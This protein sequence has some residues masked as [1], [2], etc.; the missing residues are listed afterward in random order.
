MVG[1]ERTSKGVRMHFPGAWMMALVLLCACAMYLYFTLGRIDDGDRVAYRKLSQSLDGTEVASAYT[2]KQQRRGL[3][4]DLLYNDKGQRLQMRLRSAVAEL[5]LDHHDGKVDIVENMSGVTCYIQEELFYQLS[6]GREAVRQADGR[7]LIKHAKPEDQIS[8]VSMDAP[9][10]EAM[11]VVRFFESDRASYYY[12][13]GRLVA[14]NVKVLRYLA[15]GH[16]IEEALQQ[17]VLIMSGVASFAEFNLKEANND[18]EKVTLRGNVVIEHEQGRYSAGHV[19]LFSKEGKGKDS[20]GLLRMNDDVKL[21][22]KDGGELCCGLAELDYRDQVGK[23]AGNE[24]QEFVVYKEQPA[25]KTQGSGVCTPLMVKSR[26]MAVTLAAVKRAVETSQKNSINSI[27]AEDQVTV[28]YNEDIVVSADYADYRRAEPEVVS[29]GTLLSGLITMYTATEGGL[30]QVSDSSGDLIEATRINIDTTKKQLV[31]IQPKGTLE[32]IAGATNLGRIDFIADRLEWDEQSGVFVLQDHVGVDQNGIGKLET[33]KEMRCYLN[34]GTRNKMLKS[35]ETVSDTTL[36]YH[37]AEK[38][39]HHNLFCSG[40]V[41]VDHEKME[42]RLFALRDESGKVSEDKQIHFKDPRGEVFADRVLI[43]YAT[44]GSNLEITRIILAGNVKVVN[45]P[46]PDDEE[47]PLLQY[48]LADRV[49]FTPQ[50]NEMVFRAIVKG[51]RVLFYD[52]TN[53]LQVSAPAIKINRDM[54]TKK[55]AIKGIGDVRFSFIESEFAQLRR[56][57]MLEKTGS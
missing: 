46:I 57:F 20:F 37:D 43:K 40:P 16:T 33:S 31:F 14:E 8:W 3:Q 49:D 29:K 24:Q 22:F 32:T 52:K 6:D 47:A 23:F 48:V 30:C 51:H 35:I 44:E 50:N 17:K 9:G 27:L 39:M 2:S 45:N 21:T 4:K 12:K 5:A 34:A 53:S 26:K 15:P 19:V 25:G 7:L 41:K 36:T 54:A 11:Q 38:G 1:R 42:T 56:R 18:G 10:V 28:C 13:N 55:D